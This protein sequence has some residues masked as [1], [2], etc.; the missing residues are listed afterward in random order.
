[1]VDSVNGVG[2]T[3]QIDKIKEIQLQWQKMTASQI[4]KEEKEG[5]TPPPEILR[6]AED[7]AKTSGAVDKVTYEMAQKGETDN[8]TDETGDETSG[9]NAAQADRKQMGEEG[10]SLKEQ[11]KEFT[12]K[13][14]EKEGDTLDVIGQMAPFLQEVDDLDKAAQDE[15]NKT[16]TKADEIKGE[17]DAKQGNNIDKL[18]RALG[19]DPSGKGELQGLNAVLQTLQDSSTKKIEDYG[20]QIQDV[21]TL[22]NNGASVSSD[23][24]DYGAETKDIGQEL[25]KKGNKQGTLGAV[26]GYLTLGVGGLLGGL[27]GRDNRKVGKEATQQGTETMTVADKGTEVAKD[28][29]D[30]TGVTIKS[31]DDKAKDVEDATKPDDKASDDN[32]QATDKDSSDTDAQ[33]ENKNSL[34][35]A[36]SNITTDSNEILKRKERKGLA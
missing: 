7:M 12:K 25:L 18:K 27:I 36:D 1:M 29:A 26:I 23:A 5:H 13:S 20:T 30:K 2:G 3:G 24:H 31:V 4:L 34:T 14:K 19:L 21:D 8:K 11:G 6:W 35:L 15:A 17:I 22:I 33:Q 32:A 9:M 16:K 10:L 28:A